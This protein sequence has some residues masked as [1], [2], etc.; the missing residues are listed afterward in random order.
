MCTVSYIKHRNGFSLTSNRDEQSTRPTLE[1][2]VYDE[3]HQILVYPKD[4]IAGGTWIATS[5]KNIS[6]CLLNGAFKN[7]KRQT[8]YAKSRG[9]VLKER[10]QYNDNQS[11]IDEVLLLNVEPFTLLMIDHQDLSDIDFKVLVWDGNQKHVSI[12]NTNE[13]HIWASATLYNDK[14][15]QM[16]QEWFKKFVDEHEV[17][18]TDEIIK[19]HSGSFTDDKSEDMVMQ[20]NHELKTLSISQINIHEYS[21]HF[22]YKDLETEK[23]HKINL[24]NLCETV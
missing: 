18:P 21:K 14:Q 8:P 7:H 15:R 9:M 13:P 23:N 10:F 2:Q 1:P 24:N 11:F 5:D 12:V 3:L 22:I 20:R 19:F 16:R 4:E 6:V 17:F